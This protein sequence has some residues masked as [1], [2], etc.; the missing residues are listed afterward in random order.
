MAILTPEQ[1]DALLRIIRD[2]STAVAICT[3]GYPVSAEVRKRLEDAGLVP[4]KGQQSFDF[5]LQSFEYGQLLGQGANV[6]SMDFEQ[7]QA[8]IKANPVPLSDAEKNA[9]AIAKSRAGQF[10]VGLGNR[11][12]GELGTEIVRHDAEYAKRVRA[13]IQTETADKLAKRA[14]VGELRTKLG[15]M[16]QDWARDWDRIAIT[17]SQMAHQEGFLE[18]TI[19]RHG[20]DEL[21]AKV[22]EPSACEHCV[23]HY[24]EDGKPK[25]RPASWWMAQGP[26]NAGRKAADWL[27]VMGA[28]H[29]NCRCQL[30]R[31]PEGWGFDEG[32]DLVPLDDDET[33]KALTAGDAVRLEKAERLRGGKGD[34]R[35]DSDF[36]SADLAEGMRHELEHVADTPKGRKVAKEI[37]K[38][39]LTEDADYYRKLATIEKSGPFI[40]PRGGKW[41]DAKHTIPWKESLTSAEA[42]RHSDAA[43]TGGKHGKAGIHQVKDKP[44]VKVTVPLDQLDADQPVQDGRVQDYA[45]RTSSMPAV[46]GVH[47][48]RSRRRG[49]RKIFVQDGNHRV[50]AAKRRGDTH[51]EVMIRTEDWDRFQGK[52][53]APQVGHKHNVTMHGKIFGSERK[54]TFRVTAVNDGQVKLSKHKDSDHGPVMPAESVKHFVNDLA[55]KVDLPKHGRA[56]IDAVVGG[57]A[58]FLGKGDDGLAFR[59]GDKVVKVSTTVPFQPEN[60][61]HRSPQQAIDMLRDQA[62]V[63]NKL[64]DMGIEGVQR[65]EFVVHGDKGFQIK[66]WV[67]IPDKLTQAQLDEAQGILLAIHAKGYTV[68]DQMQVG[69]DK[70]GKVVMFDIGKAGPSNDR[71]DID[72]DHSAM[73]RLYEDH[74]GKYVRQGRSAAESA[75]HSLDEQWNQ[76]TNTTDPQKL[77]DAQKQLKGVRFKLEFEAKRKF[78][79]DPKA[80]EARMGEIKYQLWAMEAE[81]EGLLEDHVEK[82]Y[83]LQGRMKFQGMDVSI[84]NRKGSVRRWYDKATETEGETKMRIPYGYIRRTEGNDGDHVD[85]FVGPD[86]DAPNVYVVHQLKAPHFKVFDEDKCMLGFRTAAEAKRAYLQHYDRPDFFGGMTT[87]PIAEFKQKVYERKGQMIKAHPEQLNLFDDAPEQSV[88]PEQLSLFDR[89]K[90]TP[91]VQLNKAEIQRRMWSAAVEKVGIPL[92]RFHLV[93]K[94]AQMGHPESRKALDE[95]HDLVKGFGT[96]TFNDGT[97]GFTQPQGKGYPVNPASTHEVG[98][99]GNFG[100]PAR[101]AHENVKPGKLEHGPK[102]AEARDDWPPQGRKKHKR[103]KRDLPDPR[104]KYDVVGLKQDGGWDR[105]YDPDEVVNTTRVDTAVMPATKEHLEEQRKVRVRLRSVMS[106]VRAY[107]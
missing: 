24:T 38:D 47:G 39:H 66:E 71:F 99:M 10:C 61:G 95:V 21:I 68:N 103:P 107:R 19:D 2:A 8:H 72:D 85:V 37:A 60:P 34:H 17:E 41:A 9:V 16:A 65:S 83:K 77:Q 87:M 78:K 31:V 42:Q 79:D 75:F 32:W 90:R 73:R 101:T 49:S 25:V 22:P 55:G 52:G 63:G 86:E 6:E 54:E 11:Y 7:L 30:V 89:I 58:E 45:G 44:H 76:L 57:K 91:V 74:G 51:I 46:Y 81:M 1:I 69:L 62:V 13:G 56:E 18:A 15:H 43:N 26:S 29:P 82:A 106:N 70:A 104:K 4:A 35:P 94:Y 67:E 23:K 14:T 88:H 50:A 93:V 36:N 100:N 92:E 84:E 64:A 59:V 40:G 48:A 12:G 27:P 33:T 98:T 105:D 20:D 102:V 80:L 28:M 97:Y 3:S 96:Q 53:D 5:V